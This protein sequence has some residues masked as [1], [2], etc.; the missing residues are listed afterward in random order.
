MTTDTADN[1]KQKLETDKWGCPRCT[2][3]NEY[4]RTHC[5]ICEQDQQPEY[6]RHNS[7]QRPQ[8]SS[9]I[10][11]A[12]ASNT[13]HNHSSS[14]PRLDSGKSTLSKIEFS[15]KQYEK[16]NTSVN[17]TKEPIISRNE[18][19]VYI[20]D[21]PLNGNESSKL[22]R[23]IC[24]RIESV[25]RIQPI[26]VK[27]YLNFGF[28]VIRVANEK[29]KDSL[30]T[31]IVSITLDKQGTRNISFVATLDL[32]SYIVLDEN[33]DND[34]TLL[35]TGEELSRRMSKLYNGERPRHCNQLNAQFPNIY[36]VVFTSFDQLVNNK[37][38]N[39]FSISGRFAHAYFCAGCSFLEDLPRS[40]NE[41]QLRKAISTSIGLSN[42][43]S[44]F[45]YVQLNKHSGSA[46][47]LVT[48]TARAWS[49]HSDLTINGKLYS[50]RDN[51]SCRLS[52]YP[53]TPSFSV[54]NIINHP[55]FVGKVTNYK[56]IGENL[57]LELSDK[58]IFD[59]CVTN[60]MLRIDDK[61]RLLVGVYNPLNNPEGSE[62]D[63]DTW[64]E[65]EMSR[66]KSDIMQFV[67]DPK[68]PI[69]RYKW[70]S[71]IWLQNFKQT[72][73]DDH[74]N[75]NV[76]D[77]KET[78]TNKTRHMLRVSVMLNTI[79]VILKGSYMIDDR[80]VKLNLDSQMKT[81]V[82]DHRSKLERCERM[83]E[84][85][86]PY[87]ST[88]VEVLN[89]DCL[90]VYERLTKSGQ[91]PLLL[92]MANATSPGGGYRKGDGAQEEN[93]FRRSDYCR[94]LDV[95]LDNVHKQP[96]K[97]YYCSS[98]C[99]LDPLSDDNNMYPMQEFGAIYTSGITVF[100]KPEHTGYSFM[101][102]PLEGVSSLAMAA[103]RDPKLEGNMLAGKY[104]VGTRKKIENI[105]AIAYYH[106]HDSL[107]LS[108]I[109]CG[110]FKNPPDHIAQLCFSVIQQYAGFFKLITFAIIDDHN[111]GHH[112][113]PEGNVQPF[114]VAFDGKSVEPLSPMN[115]PNTMFGPYLILSD[116]SSVS[117]VSIC[118]LPPCLFGANCKEMYDA[119]HAQQ[120]SHPPLCPYASITGKC[121][122][123]KNS[124]H[125]SS[126]IHRRPCQYGGECSH[127][128]E[129]KHAQEVEHPPYCPD[130]G[131]CQNMKEEHL[132]EYRHLPLC[133]KAKKCI[134]YQKHIQPHCKEYRHCTPQCQYGNHCAYFHDKEHMDEFEHPFPIPCPF[135]PFHCKSYDELSEATDSRRLSSEVQQHCLDYTHVCRTGRHCNNTNSLHLEKSI[136]IARHFCPDGNKCKKLTN[137]DHLN[138]FTHYHVDDIRL[139][140][141]RHDLCH[142]RRKLDHVV[143]FR[144][145]V[146]FEHSGIL[147]YNN[148]NEGVDFV[149]NQKDIIAR[150]TAYVKQENWKPL[151]SG[152]VPREII[153]WLNTVQPIHRCNPIVFESILIHGHVMSREYMV[154]LKYSKSVAKSVLQ[155]GRIRR[156]RELREK[157]M[158]EH[159]R[160]YII[161]LVEDIFEKEGFY[162][163]LA[164]A[165][166]ETADG[167]PSPAHIRSAVGSEVL[168]TKDRL[169]SAAL[170]SNDMD[171][172]RSQTSAIARASINLHT[173]PSG[174][175]FTKDKLLE[176]DKSVFSVLGPNLGHY[177]GDIIIVFK[178]EILHHPDANFS[179]QAATSF[180]SGN[181]FVLRPWLGTD[182]G[183][184]D[185]RV[186]LYHQSKLNASVPGY[187]HAAA[188]ELIAF[189]SFDLKLNTLNIDLDKIFKRWVTVDA[190]LTVEGHLPQLIPLSYIDHVYIPKNLYESF[191]D[192]THK[193]I[194]A[195]FKRNCTIVPFDGEANQSR[196]PHGP[197]PKSKS[198]ADY[199]DFVIKELFKQYAERREHSLSRAVRGIA[200][201]L[202][203]TDF[204]DHYVLPLTISQ[205][206]EQYRFE[207]N[208][209]PRGNMT[210]IYWQILNGDMMLT[211]SNERLQSVG[212]QPDLR[213]LTCYIAPKPTP[214]SF[215]YHEKFSY[216]NNQHPFRHYV[217]K[218]GNR[219]AAKS[220]TFYSGCNTDD[221]MTF[222]LEIE[223]STGKVT[224]S[225]A[226]PNGIYNHE[227]I[228]WTFTK[229]VLDLT[230][231]NFIHVS[232]GART[233][234]VRNLI[235]CFE[236]QVDL[237]PTFDKDYKKESS[238]SPPLPDNARQHN[239]SSDKARSPSPSRKKK[240]E[241]NASGGFFHKV[242]RFILGDGVSDLIPCHDNI[243]CLLQYSVTDTPAHNSKYSHPCLY[244]ELCR[245]KDCHLTHEP[246]KVAMCKCNKKCD[247]VVD[248]FHR[249]AYRHTDLSDFLKP[250]RDQTGCRDNSNKHRMRYSHGEKVYEVKGKEV[251]REKHDRDQRTPCRYGSK[252]WGIGDHLHCKEY[253]HPSI[254]DK[255]D[256]EEE[257]DH[258]SPCRY[259]SKCYDT[260]DRHRAEFSHSSNDSPK[261]KHRSFRQP[262]R[263]GTH[264]SKID[265]AS[266]CAQFSHKKDGN[267]AD[268]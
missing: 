256:S 196:G 19:L 20:P 149:Q 22:E 115:K 186:K 86:P 243:N 21:L 260:S 208:H 252:C 113:N 140:C 111:A 261:I 214:N 158:E 188:L 120:Y 203:S 192:D 183:S 29:E 58:N 168:Q 197:I 116:G 154:K 16:E 190:H 98:N 108:A 31:E 235:I 23:Q 3:Q 240:D 242:K 74:E 244:S 105:F 83:P 152:G 100:R 216:L 129:K 32:V 265:D 195:N 28:G 225:H 48:D 141:R 157:I 156:I 65:T 215:P 30:V 39:E 54:R 38:D 181:A 80:E 77:R 229:G 42:L 187:E 5:E 125:M 236:K 9:D 184:L 99:Q 199:Q 165:T 64:Y 132:R 121:P 134:D 40:L 61:L 135:T 234:P 230:K 146:T 227:T 198:R 11:A 126:L 133:N 249:A 10:T 67:S 8:S 174:I 201:T 139:P 110:A 163:Y 24:E 151:P 6:I 202:P 107:V 7:N 262:C 237:H 45:L 254:D 12:Y 72:L 182:P 112:L 33:Q 246:H 161:A 131:N 155:H 267:L 221:L 128:D 212:S 123:K 127:I 109:G 232:A 41:D 211:L 102:K 200:I 13:N 204:T 180:A 82:Y 251:P 210:Y 25:C 137:E 66:Y 124:I 96:S 245:N 209:R 114:R 231:L 264:C 250:C 62:I 142:D 55:M 248:P 177:Y 119:K 169:L 122:F 167:D 219:F 87:K 35:P 85:V 160:Q 173:N 97:R 239:K 91:R 147:H 43:S 68:H 175:G 255:N 176:T 117:D 103:Y 4:S 46:C 162:T 226:G 94:S 57:I 14:N 170:K 118:D 18:T 79:G 101:K 75:K 60:G 56:Q 27:C 15:S 253:S 228:F 76:R 52:V 89:E 178:R 90:L 36:R 2:F 266:H 138:S 172:I 171:A 130:K 104:A 145:A 213:C 92:N 258:Q 50:K 53:I 224:L 217:L 26:D 233:V 44:S 222:C 263:Y 159:A 34:D 191:S 189:S 136:H 143:K 268:N 37:Y 259:G 144:H 51:L 49:A 207:K 88:R 63:N 1:N 148:L 257:K 218:E 223:R 17:L 73:P 59:K 71:E 93:L 70:N 185:E 164:T 241:D 84:T 193:A 220:N 205:A 179:I 153:E 81:I 238:S 206:Y 47:I 247:Q 69:F 106:K 166:A 95:G 78:E 150:V 194:N